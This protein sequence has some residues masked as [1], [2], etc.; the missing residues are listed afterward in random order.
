MRSSHDTLGLKWGEGPEGEAGESVNK[1]I[2]RKSESG[3]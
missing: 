3:V 1:L 2:G